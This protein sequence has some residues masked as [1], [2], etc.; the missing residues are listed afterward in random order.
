MKNLE[1]KAYLSMLEI[2]FFIFLC[3][4]WWEYQSEFQIGMCI[5]LKQ[6][7]IHYLAQIM[8]WLLWKSFLNQG[9]MR[10][11]RLWRLKDQ[12]ESCQKLESLDLIESFLR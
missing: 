8:S 12:S 3:F 10:V 11:L 7:R 2:S 5:Y 1:N 4:F 6:M 9:N